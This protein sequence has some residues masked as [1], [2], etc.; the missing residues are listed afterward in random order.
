MNTIVDGFLDATVVGGFSRIGF[1]ARSRGWARPRDADMRGKTVV[2][3]G[4]TAGLGLA[5]VEELLPTGARLVLVARNRTK[6]DELVALLHS[7]RPD[8]EVVTVIADMGELDQVRAAATR[9]ASLAGSIDV[10]VHNAGALL[11][12]RTLTSGGHETTMSTHVYGPHLMTEMLLARLGESKGRVVTVASG[13][14]YAADLPHFERGESPEMGPDTY[15]GTRQ[16]ATAKRAQV[17][18]T[19]MW[20]LR[21]P[22]ITWASMHPGWA[23]TPGVQS[24]LPGFRRVTKPI[25]RTPAQGADT[26]AWLSVVAEL[27][28]PNGSFWCDRRPRPIHRLGHTRRSDTATQRQALWR[29]VET[30]VSGGTSNGALHG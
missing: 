29:W 9:I 1:A 25:L 11:A 12:E 10:L 15:D 6:L 19:A 22:G 7:R 27:D 18:L 17:T 8:A 16:Y 21:E 5:T 3:T 26:I 24:S 28:A 2:V 4:P 30:V 13:G 20:A 23:D 14:M